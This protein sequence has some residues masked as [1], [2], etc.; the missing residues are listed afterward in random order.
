MN[1]IEFFVSAETKIFLVLHTKSA[2]MMKSAKSDVYT[3]VKQNPSTSTLLDILPPKRDNSF[4]MKLYKVLNLNEHPDIVRW[5][6]DG[7]FFTI[8]KRPQF[9]S[10]VLKESFN[11][12]KMSSFLRQLNMYSFSK[13]PQGI[14]YTHPY[15][16]KANPELLKLIKRRQFP[17]SKKVEHPPVD[18]GVRVADADADA[19]AGASSRARLAVVTEDGREEFPALASDRPIV[20]PHISQPRAKLTPEG[21][22]RRCAYMERLFS[23]DNPFKGVFEEESAT[24]ADAEQS[25]DEDG[26]F[27][28][29]VPFSAFNKSDAK[30]FDTQDPDK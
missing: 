13:D 6:N 7:T 15:F 19:D 22:C 23:Q 27:S 1:S 21:V 26:M 5:S 8:E 14:M 17:A 29:T 10:I 18:C 12:V 3:K 28:S 4:I 20:S 9:I 11:G 25:E 30:F 16:T 2:A 24:E